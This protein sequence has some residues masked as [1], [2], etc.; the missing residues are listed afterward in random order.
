MN[1]IELANEIE[2]LITENTDIILGGVTPGINVVYDL[3]GNPCL[4]VMEQTDD[5]LRKRFTIKITD[6]SIRK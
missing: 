5:G 1:S 3:D 2:N 4:N 6:D